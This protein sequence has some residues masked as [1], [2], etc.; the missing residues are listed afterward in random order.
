LR[1]GVLDELIGGY[2]LPFLDDIAKH[3]DYASRAR[4]WM[5]KPLKCGLEPLPLIAETMA[6]HKHPR[7]KVAYLKELTRAAYEN[8]FEVEPVIPFLRHGDELRRERAEAM[9]N[10]PSAMEMRQVYR[11]TTCPVCGANALSVYIISVDQE[12]DGQAYDRDV[13]DVATCD[14]CSLELRH[15][16]GNASEHKLTGIENYFGPL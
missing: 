14:G 16:F 11:V 2:A 10:L 1:Y 3:P 6:T 8:P 7:A 13:A 15:E 4:R 5:H 9:A 12:F